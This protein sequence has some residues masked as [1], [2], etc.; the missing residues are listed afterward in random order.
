MLSIARIAY[1]PDC[2]LLFSSFKT[3]FIFSTKI[4]YCGALHAIF[5]RR[6]SMYLRTCGSFKS[7]KKAVS[8]NQIRIKDWSGLQ[9]CSLSG[10]GCWAGV[11]GRGW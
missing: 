5:L 2:F 11:D 6:K 9:P 8:T 10:H 4:N 3:I 7:A 1:N